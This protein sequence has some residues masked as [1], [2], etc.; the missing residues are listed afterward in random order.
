MVNIWYIIIMILCANIA[1]AKDLGV[2]GQV[3]SIKEHD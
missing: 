3:F 2:Y 1:A